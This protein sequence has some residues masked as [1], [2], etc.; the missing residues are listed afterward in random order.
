[1][2]RPAG[3]TRRAAA[4]QGLKSIGSLLAVDEA[5]QVVR[6]DGPGPSGPQT[7]SA[8][9]ECPFATAACYSRLARPRFPT[10]IPDCVRQAIDARFAVLCTELRAAVQAVLAANVRRRA[11]GP[12]PRNTHVRERSPL[13][14]RRIVAC[15]PRSREH[16][17]HEE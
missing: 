15:N 6:P 13:P 11:P 7:G 12:A 2:L 9:M 8:R 3:P 17:H 4:V 16:F 10:A 5:P 1:M 14:N